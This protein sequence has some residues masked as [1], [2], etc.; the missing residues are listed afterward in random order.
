V[1]DATAHWEQ[2]YRDREPERLS[3]YEPWPAT[4]LSLIEEAALS[5]HAAILDV[6][7]GTSKLA[8]ELL[9]AGYLGVTVVDIAANALERARAELGADASRVKWIEADIRSHEFDHRFDLWHDRAVFHFMVAPDDRARYVS[10]LWR[11]LR[12]GGQVIIATFGPDGPSQCSGLPVTRYGA[13]GLSEV[14]GEDLEL[15]SSRL[16]QHRT[17]GGRIQQ[18]LYAHFRLRPDGES[19]STKQ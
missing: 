11:A 14:L 7:G 2:I 13:P 1:V 4:S 19:Q 3:W 6:G 5:S 9:A 18:L 12:P 17:P 16:E 8:G 15:I 10:A